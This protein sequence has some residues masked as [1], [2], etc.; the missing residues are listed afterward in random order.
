[1][2]LQVAAQRGDA[3]ALEPPLGIHAI[4]AL[5]TLPQLRARRSMSSKDSPMA[6]CEANEG[7]VA[8][9]GQARR[10]LAPFLGIAL[11]LLDPREGCAG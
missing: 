8:G 5:G 1:V 9:S 6:A 7:T 11:V 10:A 3:P 4:V 2:L